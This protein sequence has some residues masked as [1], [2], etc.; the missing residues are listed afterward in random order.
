MF[1]DS[2]LNFSKHIKEKAAIAMKGIS[3]LKKCSKYVY[4]NVLSF[5][6]KMYIRPHLDYGGVIYHNQRADL[7]NLVERVQYKA[8]LIVSGCWQGTSREKLYV[9][10]GWESSSDRRWLR[11]LTIFYKICNGL[12]PYYL[13]DHIP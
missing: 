1:L 4:R 11:R 9:E 7:M 8:A 6:Y 12:A 13:C 3:L 10:L 5:P 2:R